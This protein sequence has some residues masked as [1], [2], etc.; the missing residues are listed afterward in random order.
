M[1]CKPA[2]QPVAGAAIT[3]VQNR[4]AMSAT[5]IGAGKFSSLALAE[6]RRMASLS[7][8]TVGPCELPRQRFLYTQQARLRVFAG[9]PAHFLAFRIAQNSGIVL[10]QRTRVGF[11]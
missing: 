5:P 6:A 11:C 4:T 3:Q 1:A 8:R 9:N 10:T 7:G 2:R